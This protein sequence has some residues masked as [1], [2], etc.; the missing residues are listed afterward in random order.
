MTE[1]LLQIDAGKVL[2]NAKLILEDER[3][4]P[5]E[6]PKK[7][8]LSLST[9]SLSLFHNEITVDLDS[10]PPE[11]KSYR[12]INPICRECGIDGN[13]NRFFRIVQ[14]LGTG[15]IVSAEGKWDGDL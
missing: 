1:K 11:V 8:C 5:K 6:C 7:K 13:G 9:I 12:D 4:L 14:N 10:D 2:S 15:K 3:Q